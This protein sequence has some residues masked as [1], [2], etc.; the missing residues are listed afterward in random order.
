MAIEDGYQLALTLDRAVTLVQPGVA[1]D[2]EAALKAYAGVRPA[3]CTPP[4][5]LWKAPPPPCIT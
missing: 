5:L 4:V 2:L 3:R 1:V